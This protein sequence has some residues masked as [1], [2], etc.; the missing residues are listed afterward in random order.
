MSDCPCDGKCPNCGC[1]Q[2]PKLIEGFDIQEVKVR[3]DGGID[4]V[5]KLKIPV[6]HIP[7][8]LV[9]TDEE[10]ER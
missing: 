6:K 4:A 5:I 7:L 8:T 3:P 10:K 2:D 9:V 1:Q